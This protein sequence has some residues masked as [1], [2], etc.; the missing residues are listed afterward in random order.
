MVN[1]EVGG[2]KKRWQRAQSLAALLSVLIA[3]AFATSCS[4]SQRCAKAYRTGTLRKVQG[5]QALAQGKYDEALT[6]YQQAKA[7]L[8]KAE[9]LFQAS[10][11]VVSESGQKLAKGID[12][13]LGAFQNPQGAV[14][15]VLALCGSGED[16][17]IALVLWNSEG[18]AVN[19]LGPERWQA[20]SPATRTQCAH[21]VEALLRSFVDSNRGFFKDARSTFVRE[22]AEGED[23][24]VEM[25][26]EYGR[27]KFPMQVTLRMDKGLWRAVNFAS[28]FANIA[29]HLATSF[30]SLERLGPL[31]E[32]VAK[33]DAVPLFLEASN[34]AFDDASAQDQNTKVAAL[35]TATSFDLEDGRT[36]ALSENVMVERLGERR[37]MEGVAQVKV[38]LLGSLKVDG[39]PII[40]AG[41]AKGWIREEALP[42]ATEEVW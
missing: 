42:G 11:S 9:P 32:M 8:D 24:T 13:R 15:A 26:I 33:P 37:V 34:M 7:V 28:S 19:A 40:P 5:D 38:R 3:L 25:T 10:P 31:E 4:K 18:L 14:E 12:L 1:G 27:N 29:E 21:L 22:T 23:K 41:V 16:D 30:A 20:L 39:L 17:D 35:T 36:Y 6:F 2:A